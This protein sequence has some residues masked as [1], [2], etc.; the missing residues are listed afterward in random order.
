ML[1]D[2][3]HTGGRAEMEGSSGGLAVDACALRCPLSRRSKSLSPRSSCVGSR[4]C[5]ADAVSAPR[6]LVVDGPSLTKDGA[7]SVV[8][9]ERQPVVLTPTRIEHGSEPLLS[10]Q[11]R[12]LIKSLPDY[13]R[14]SKPLLVGECRS[15]EVV[16]SQYA[17]DGVPLVAEQ[18]RLLGS[19]T[20][21]FPS[22][23]K[24]RLLA[25][26]FEELVGQ[27]TTAYKQLEVV[28]EMASAEN[29]SLRRLLEQSR[30][31]TAKAQ[32]LLE[33]EDKEPSVWKTH[34]HHNSDGIDSSISC[35]AGRNT[36]ELS[37]ELAE[38]PSVRSPRSSVV[39]VLSEHSSG[40]DSK[41]EPRER[42]SPC[43][44][45][46]IIVSMVL[47]RVSFASGHA[48]IHD[49]WDNALVR[50]KNLGLTAEV[51]PSI[52]TGFRVR[53]RVSHFGK[54]AARNEA[55]YGPLY[56]EEPWC[57][58][59]H[60]SSRLFWVFVG[61]M[62]MGY[63][64][65]SFTLLVFDMQRTT[66]TKVVTVVGNVYWSVDIF[67]SFITAIFVQGTLCK[68]HKVII[69][70]YLKTWFVFDLGLAVTQWAIF[71]IEEPGTRVS[72]FGA[73]KYVR[74]TRFSRIIRMFKMF[75]ILPSILELITSPLC[76]L[77]LEIAQFFLAMLF[78]IHISACGFYAV[79]RFSTDPAERFELADS[80]GLQYVLSA[81][82]AASQLQ[83]S[84]DVVSGSTM[85]QRCYA[86]VSIMVSILFL[87]MFISRLTN[88]LAE[89]H[90]LTK[91]NAK[92][93]RRVR[94]YLCRH[95]ISFE[96]SIQVQKF[97]KW[98]QR[99]E[100]NRCEKD[101]DVVLQ[102]LPRHLKAA[103]LKE[104]HAPCL[105]KHSVFQVLLL[106]FPSLFQNVCIE[107]LRSIVCLPD[108]VIFTLGELPTLTYIIEAGTITFNHYGV[109]ARTLISNTNAKCVAM[110]SRQ[111]Q[112]LLTAMHLVAG[113]IVTEMALWTQTAHAG[114]LVAVNE[115]HILVVHAQTF[116]ETTSSFPGP[117][118]ALAKHAKR[119]V[120]AL[121][122]WEH[123]DYD[124]FTTL[125]LRCQ[126]P[127]NLAEHHPRRP[128]G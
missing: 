105:C 108:E 83:G 51:D 112:Q 32:I 122:C 106:E 54:T 10:C 18:Q 86:V 63:D 16:P 36:S 58:H 8:A 24:P 125:D 98:K 56:K 128:N 85:Q 12:S 104:T 68:N 39:T 21:S 95:S 55:G 96:I 14:D 76:E 4:E 99:L 45:W 62:F 17:E 64:M 81:H 92:Q 100:K 115:A 70:T 38:P 23:V 1:M 46:K 75:A 94:D 49:L 34:A 61:L 37:I 47:Q 20:S 91:K 127:G 66:F 77:A 123:L 90:E 126:T 121:A 82:W 30:T 69:L 40:S 13:D 109:V 88:I 110:T 101:D 43:E 113:R 53:H 116:I 65:I 80:A 102:L 2:L 87:A 25:R 48:V 120:R 22:D 26:P 52:F 74:M 11:Y 60:S 119:F 29:T 57:L 3:L 107:A 7:V 73:L 114:D 97:V 79:D 19:C 41:S 89:M 111:R 124:L 42:L 59:P 15:V 5:P 118:L 93:S 9:D 71:V 67:L 28:Y 117:H 50:A 35:F 27:I 44:R 33:A 72:R 31:E 103:V 84:T 78:W 6:R